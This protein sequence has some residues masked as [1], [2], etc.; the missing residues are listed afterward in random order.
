VPDLRL[1]V[2]P[3][4][5][6]SIWITLKQNGFQGVWTLLK[7]ANEYSIDLVVF[8]KVSA[9]KPS[10]TIP[11]TNE[12]HEWPESRRGAT[13]CALVVSTM[14]DLLAPVTAIDNM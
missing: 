12:L 1:F 14:D 13:C 7:R 9:L 4:H 2:Y 10:V 3:E 6:Y 5:G 8:L 11:R